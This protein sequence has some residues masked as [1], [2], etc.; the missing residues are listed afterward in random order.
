MPRV[1]L[2]GLLALTLAACTAGADPEPPDA[3]DSQVAETD[4]DTDATPVPGAWVS[5]DLERNTSPSVTPTDLQSLTASNRAFALDLYQGVRAG[6]DNLFL[7]PHSVSLALAMTY[8]GAES[9]T[10]TEMATALH[11]DLSE[12]GLHEAFNSLD[13]ELATREDL[14]PETSGN[15]FR[16]SI[17]NQTF[18]Q[19]GFGFES[20]FLD[21]LAVNYGA[22]MRLLDFVADPDGS[23]EEINDWVAAQTEDRILDLLP[24]G[25]VDT[26]T[27]LVLANAIYFKASWSIPFEADD[28]TDD[29]FTLLAG[30]TASVPTMHGTLDASW[31]SG[32]GWALAELPYVGEQV[33]MG[34]LVPDE[35][36]F[37]AIE[38]G[39]DAAFVDAAVASLSGVELTLGLPK[40]Q[41]ESKLDLAPPLKAL[42]MNQA[43]TTSADFTGM[44]SEADLMVTGVFHQ[45]FIDVNEEGTEA[46]AA[47]AVVIGTTSM[48]PQESMTVD[49]PF[50][51]W[52]RDAPTGA[53]LFLGRVTDP[54]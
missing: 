10:E 30:T 54:R 23:R 1:H 49:R 51:F 15:G 13:L 16:L 40:F 25:S 36:Q 2:P 44:S 26:L 7:S 17:V 37:E 22:G 33:K 28:T 8:A 14:P 39:L 47:T 9:T 5:S 35:G 24:P 41:F 6:T 50:L 11:F 38:A 34:L 45:S 32:D 42:G 52:I 20:G 27:R 29:D 12:P 3:D 43:F 4:V 53:L 18:G 19:A 48:P 31:A 21:T 46:A